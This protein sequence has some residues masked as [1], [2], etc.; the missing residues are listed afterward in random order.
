[1]NAG[2]DRFRAGAVSDRRRGLAEVTPPN[3][4]EEFVK[5]VEN[6]GIPYLGGERIVIWVGFDTKG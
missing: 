5:V 4:S 6:V 1:M 3:Q 2:A